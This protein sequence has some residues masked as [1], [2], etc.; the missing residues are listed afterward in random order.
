MPE[1]IFAI[2]H[3]ALAARGCRPVEPRK[4]NRAIRQNF[5]KS[6]GLL[7]ISIAAIATIVCT[8]YYEIKFALVGYYESPLTEYAR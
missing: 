6:G 2:E 4:Q 3:L 5:R 8:A 1:V 7:S